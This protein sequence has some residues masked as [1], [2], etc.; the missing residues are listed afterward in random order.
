MAAVPGFLSTLQT[1]VAADDRNAVAALVRY[2]L[3]TYNNGVETARYADAAALIAAYDT[4]FTP[5]VKDAIAKATPETLFTNIDGV[6]IG[7]GE[8]WIDN[9]SLPLMIKTINAQQ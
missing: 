1:A 2:P 8:V 7:N 5:A 3:V 4:L 9:S 6:M